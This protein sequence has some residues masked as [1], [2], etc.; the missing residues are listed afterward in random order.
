M[1]L[2]N[3]F[4]DCRFAMPFVQVIHRSA[5]GAVSAH[6][7]SHFHRS[8]EPGSQPSSFAQGTRTRPHEELCSGVVTQ[9]V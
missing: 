7:S 3:S 6:Q 4:L 2:F 8:L 1:W 9:A 5:L